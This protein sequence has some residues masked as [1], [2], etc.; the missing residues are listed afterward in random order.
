MLRVECPKHFS[1]QS[2][3]LTI[4]LAAFGLL[5]LPQS[6]LPTLPRMGPHHQ[7][8]V[9]ALSIVH[10]PASTTGC[11][12]EHAFITSFCT[13]PN[14][15]TACGCLLSNRPSD[16][17]EWASPQRS[18]LMHGDES[19][20]ANF[21]VWARTSRYMYMFITSFYTGH[22]ADPSKV[23]AFQQAVWFCGW[24]SPQGLFWCMTSKLSLPSSLFGLETSRCL[25]TFI[26]SWYTGHV[27][28]PKNLGACGCLL[29]HRR[30]NYAGVSP[31]GLFWYMGSKLP[32]PSSLFGLETSRCLY[33]FITSLCTGHVAAPNNV[34]ACGCLL[35]HR[36]SDIAG[37]ASPRS[38]QMYGIEASPC[39]LHCLGSKHP[40]VCLHRERLPTWAR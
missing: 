36:P 38:L 10:A 5:N 11:M 22:V 3:K 30:S 31:K 23:P 17:C 7:H 1:K 8:V 37:I 35:L 39:H 33:T 9:E 18:V 19:P 27:A 4:V 21:I 14:M 6:L 32:H 20:P 15:V 24:A 25:Y 34:R 12:L 40:D 13:G 26:T 28:A 2:S 16:F 29:S